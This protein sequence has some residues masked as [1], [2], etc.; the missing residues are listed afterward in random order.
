MRSSISAFFAGWAAARSPK[1]TSGRGT[2]VTVYFR[3]NDMRSLML[4]LVRPMFWRSSKPVELTV[5]AETEEEGLAFAQWLANE[6]H[7]SFRK[8]P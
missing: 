6:L 4:K 8:W 2:V 1:V 3:A 7:V 5:G